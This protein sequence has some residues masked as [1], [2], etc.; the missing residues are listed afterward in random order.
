M[1]V[2]AHRWLGMTAL[3][4][5]EFADIPARSL[6]PLYVFYG[7]VFYLTRALG[8]LPRFCL[9]AL[10]VLVG[11]LS[12]WA[13]AWCVASTVHRLRRSLALFFLAS[14][15][16]SIVHQSRTFSNSM[17]SVLVC[18]AVALIQKLRRG[19]LPYASAMALGACCALGIFTRITFAAFVLLPVLL[20]LPLL[21]QKPQLAISAA[22]AFA[23]CL[24]AS[25]I[26]DTMGFTGRTF[27]NTLHLEW[28]QFVVAPLNNLFYN[29]DV[30]NL[31][32][33][34]IHP[35]YTHL[36]VNLPQLLGPGLL[37]LGR[38]EDL[39]SMPALAALGG[40]ALLSLA[41]H[42]EL[43]F[44]LPVVPLLCTLF[45]A[46]TPLRVFHISKRV[47]RMLYASWLIFNAAMCVLMG[48]LHQ[49]GVIPALT[50]WREQIA[51]NEHS[52]LGSDAQSSVALVWWR[53]YS[54]PNWLLGDQNGTVQVSG[55]FDRSKHIHVYDVMGMDSLALQSMLDKL[56]TEV[57]RVILIAPCGSMNTATDT[58]LFEQIWSTPLHLDLDHLDFSNPA[59]LQPGLGMYSLL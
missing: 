42:Q 34:G 29:T 48:I 15:Y 47:Q 45:D 1:E 33:H 26:T 4:P 44:L 37:F 6:V 43:R 8:L 12:S 50:F 53:T 18:C 35:R 38:K 54:P 17:E 27:T 36:L 24:A 30:A 9:V 7:P 2:L 59:S 46:E 14:S 22:A 32:L 11:L 16:T 57:D 21:F 39:L 49:G 41:P 10:R 51:Y 3:E 55:P 25:V 5:W 58:A 19:R 23:T 13:A 20:L 31:A 56:R 52:S 40:L 28:L